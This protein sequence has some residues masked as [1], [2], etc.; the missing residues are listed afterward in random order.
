MATFN[1]FYSFCSHYCTGVHDLSTSGSL[2]KYYLSNTAPNASAHTIKGDLA[3]IT[4]ENGYTAPID[5][6]N[7]G[8]MDN[9]TG[10]FDITLSATTITATGGTVGPFQYVVIYD[11]TP[12]DPVDPL[13]GWWDR[14]A[15]LTLQDGDSFGIHPA[16]STI[17]LG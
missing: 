17:T 7:V 5:S 15:A 13:I 12:T 6:T 9:G 1:K 14:G 16:A 4:N 3:E 8:A 11:D 2:I 10:I